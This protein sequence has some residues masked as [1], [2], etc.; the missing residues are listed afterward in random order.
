[1]AWL[2][3]IAGGDN[4]DA[5]RLRCV[6][7]RSVGTIQKISDDLARLHEEHDNETRAEE[8]I[9]QEPA[10]KEKQ[11]QREEVEQLHP[12]SFPRSAW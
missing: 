12:F 8:K 10:I 5:E 4:C 6:T 3:L 7:T 1:M 9:R 2:I 11:K